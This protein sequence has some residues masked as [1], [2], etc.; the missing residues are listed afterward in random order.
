MKASGSDIKTRD[1]L[2]NIKNTKIS[3][4]S[5]VKKASN[6]VTYKKQKIPKKIKE[7]VWVK[8]FKKT[9]ESKCCISW[10]S[11][12]I[13]VF[14]FQV[15]HNIP[16]SK[17]GTMTL[18]NLKPICDRC[19]YSMGANYTIDEWD[20]KVINKTPEVNQTKMSIIRLKINSLLC[21]ISSLMAVGSSIYNFY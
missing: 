3:N 12:N 11:N 10:C 4:K 19:N 17:G 6:N 8:Y 16:E 7:E 20:I 15:G 1:T 14:N 9:F 5:Q 18:D 21:G 13:N 2:L